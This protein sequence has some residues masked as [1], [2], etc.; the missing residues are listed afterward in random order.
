MCI[1]MTL[2]HWPS[3]QIYPYTYICPFVHTHISVQLY[4]H[5]TH[6]HYPS[7]TLMC[8][9]HMSMCECM[10]MCDINV[11]VWYA[12]YVWEIHTALT[13]MCECHMYLICQSVTS[14]REYHMYL[15][16]CECH[17]YLICQSVT[18]MC[19]CDMCV[20]ECVSITCN[21]RTQ[22]LTYEIHVTY[23]HKR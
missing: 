9:C 10:S 17:M 14:M 21:I 20:K 13:S 18:S 16:M 5:T 11:W 19:R 7:H 4:I 6:T 8:E 12:C 3:V 15:S 2:T 22:T 23:A 1:H